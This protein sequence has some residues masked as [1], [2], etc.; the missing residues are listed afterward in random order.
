MVDKS[1]TVC[2][3]GG[4]RVLF[5]RNSLHLWEF[6][7]SCLS[8]GDKFRVFVLVFQLTLLLVLVTFKT[9]LVSWACVSAGWKRSE[10]NGWWLEDNLCFPV[11]MMLVILPVFWALF[12]RKGSAGRSCVVK[13]QSGQHIPAVLVLM[14]ALLPFQFQVWYKTCFDLQSSERDRNWLLRGHFCPCK[15]CNN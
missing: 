6:L 5:A 3:L 11:I 10:I 15:F 1:V 13:H 4:N 7:S 12:W 2:S 14:L 9:S 8:V